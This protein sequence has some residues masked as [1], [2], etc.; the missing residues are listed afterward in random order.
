MGLRL[1]AGSGILTTGSAITVA[2][3]QTR[4]KRPLGCV[5]RA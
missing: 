5:R 2:A 1:H 4:R 3:W